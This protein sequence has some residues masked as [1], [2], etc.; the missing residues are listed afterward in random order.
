MASQSWTQLSNFHSLILFFTVAVPIYIL[1]HTA[2]STYPLWHLLFVDFLMIPILTGVRWLI[3]HYSFDL[4]LSNNL[5]TSCKELPH[6]KRLWCWEGLGA[7]E[8]ND[9]GWDGWIGITHSMDVSLSELLEFTPGVMDREA[10]RAAIHG[11]A[12]FRTQLS[13]QTELGPQYQ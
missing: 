11:V 3:P 13:D 8:G 4:H 6:W 2:S 1:P 7:G 12:K 5:A 9:R 10:W